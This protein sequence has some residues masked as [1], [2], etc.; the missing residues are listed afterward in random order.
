MHKLSLIVDTNFFHECR[1][2]ETLNW[3]ILGSFDSIN[4][5]VTS[6]VIAELDK[7]KNDSKPRIKRR[8]LKV[9]TILASIIDANLEPYVIQETVPR[10]LLTV[11]NIA[12][13]R[14]YSHI[15]D[16]RVTDDMIVATACALRDKYQD[17][18]FYLLSGDLG[19]AA[20]ALDPDI[21]LAFK[22]IP[23]EWKRGLEEDEEQKKIRR[24]KEELA[25]YTKQEPDI[26]IS[27]KKKDDQEKTD[28]LVLS[29]DAFVSL[30][31][32]EVRKLEKYLRNQYPVEP[33]PYSLV[34]SHINRFYNANP[35]ITLEEYYN[36]E[37]EH[38]YWLIES[39]NEFS[40]LDKNFNNNLSWIACISIDNQGSIPAQNVTV[41]LTAK[42][43][44]KVAYYCERNISRN[45]LTNP[46]CLPFAS[47]IT[48]N[49]NPY[50][51]QR[52]LDNID[53]QP[54]KW[55]EFTF[56]SLQHQIGAQ[57]LWIDIFAEDIDEQL[58]AAIEVKI[59]AAN[60]PTSIKKTI[61]VQLQQKKCLALF[62]K[63]KEMIDHIAD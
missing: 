19:V 34:M 52:N 2:I 55:I 17:R 38:N 53:Y 13:S 10:V 12:P 57:K 9:N 3:A 41:R 24:L 37:R 54:Y 59:F 50:S 29:R 31:Y 11:E 48:A 5:I 61:S 35:G 47:G 16:D 15:L 27:V 51:K 7:Q 45:I 56:D 14:Q 44:I 62:D 46:P 42:G 49:Y 6:R 40:K 22:R 23:D 33:Q 30:T 26:Q 8:A 36:Y 58:N 32:E 39:E 4:V 28:K 25:K 18:E 60:I 1:E 21:Q 43:K 63:A 20:K